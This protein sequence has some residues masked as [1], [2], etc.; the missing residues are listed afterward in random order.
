MHNHHGNIILDYVP[1]GCTSIAQ[2]CDVGIQRPFKLSIKC[3]Y[4]EDVVMEIL[5]QLNTNVSPIIVDTRLP[6]F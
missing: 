4:H 3:S 6:K 1:G 2:P 5:E